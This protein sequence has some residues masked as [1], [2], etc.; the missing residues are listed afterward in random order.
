MLFREQAENF[1]KKKPPMS[2]GLNLKKQQA[3]M[4]SVSTEGFDDLRSTLEEREYVLSLFMKMDVSDRCAVFK[5]LVF[6]SLVG[7]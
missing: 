6:R 3:W 1:K 4:R 7:Y 2:S 5:L